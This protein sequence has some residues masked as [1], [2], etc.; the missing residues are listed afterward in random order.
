[1]HDLRVTLSPGT[2]V[3][4]GE[5]L[6]AISSID[7]CRVGERRRRTSGR[8]QPGRHRC[9]GHG[10]VG[11]GAGPARGHDVRVGTQPVDDV[12]V[13]DGI[14]PSTDPADDGAVL[15]VKF[16]DQHGLPDR[17]DGAGCRRPLVTYTGL[18]VAP[19][20]FFYEGPEGTILAAGELAIMYLPLAA[21]QDISG[22]EGWS[23]MQ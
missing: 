6:A 9:R 13:R 10:R 12:W 2:F 23:T 18:G 5:L 21:A 22:N 17:G 14:A 19:E 1:M 15:E 11:P 8:R 7:G 3:E 20:D 16:A 4:Q